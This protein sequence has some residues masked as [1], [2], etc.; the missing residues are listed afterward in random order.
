MTI[1]VP[2]DSGR[3]HIRRLYSEVANMRD[4]FIVAC[5]LARRSREG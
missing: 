5:N 3:I 4:T 1:C 2:L